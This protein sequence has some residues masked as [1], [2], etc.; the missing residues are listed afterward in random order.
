ML[1]WLVIGGGIHGTHLAHMLVNQYGFSA[2]AVR[3]LDPHK[4]LLATWTQRT[5]NTGM[6]YLRSPRVHHIDLESNSL[7]R[8]A[9]EHSNNSD[10]WINPYHRPSYA[11]FQQHCQHVIGTYQLDRLHI[12]GQAL[13]LHRIKGA[14]CVDTANDRLVSQ[15]VLLA[16]GQQ[17]RQIPDWAERIIKQN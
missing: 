15:R 17:Q 3:I 1:D 2:D 10:L 14:W 13:T 8:F 11:L 6:R 7:E 5:K 4:Q 16:T 9:Q 12:Q